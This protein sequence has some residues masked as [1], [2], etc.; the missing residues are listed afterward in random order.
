MR[1]GI[2]T[3][4]N[5]A[6]V[7]ATLLAGGA[8]SLLKLALKVALLELALRALAILAAQQECKGKRKTGRKERRKGKERGGVNNQ[9]PSEKE[10]RG[11]RRT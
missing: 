10:S 9:I 7:P 1:Q 3:K 6:N 11:E 4:E 5:K 2:N 8:L